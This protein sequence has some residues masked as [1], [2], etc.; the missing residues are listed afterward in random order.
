MLPSPGS[1]RST[2]EGKLLRLPSVIPREGVGLARALETV[3]AIRYSLENVSATHLDP[4]AAYQQWSNEAARRLPYVF[5]PEDVERLVLT[6]RHWALQTISSASMGDVRNLVHTETEDR[7]RDLALI[8]DTY[9]QIQ[10]LWAS[11]AAT[12]VAP[13]TNVYLHQSRRFDTI[14]WESLAAEAVRLIVPEITVRELDRQKT[15]GKN[16]PVVPGSNEKVPTRAR[17]TVRILREYLA[18]PDAAGTIRSRLEVE[19][20][21][22]PLDHKRLDDAD[23]EFLARLVAM[24][25]LT[26]RTILVATSDAGMEMM[27]RIN[28]L[29]VLW[30]EQQQS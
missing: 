3:Q 6:R 29:Q 2:H 11:A 30:L 21:A 19:F 23:S 1:Y 13:D 12:L 26:G 20:L 5:D 10:Q 7:R 8:I 14:D 24:Q 18:N 22:N 17:H 15:Y 16:V 4:L 9:S 25:R 28:G 27:A